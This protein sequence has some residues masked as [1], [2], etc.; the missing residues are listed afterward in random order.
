MKEQINKRDIAIIGLS[1]K[2]SASPDVTTFWQN[3]KEGKELTT[4]YSKEELADL[5][6]SSQLSAHPDFVAVDG[7]MK[8]TDQFD[9]DFFGYS[10]EEAAVMDPQIRLFHQL[11]WSAL[12][13]AAYDPQTFQGKIGLFATAS[14]NLLWRTYTRLMANEN[15]NPFFANLISN[16][17]FISLLPAFK[18]NLRGPS[19]FLDTAC[20]SS[21]VAFHQACR[22]LML[23][24]CHMA[25]AGG[26]R[27]SM[28]KSAGYLYEEGMIFSQDGH[29]RTFDERA[30]GTVEGEGGGVVVLKRLSEAI[31][32]GDHIYAIVKATA[33][34]NDGKHK[35]GFTAPSV[36]GQSSC[37]RLAYRMAGV[38]PATVSYVE[39]HGTGTKLGDP[40][41]IGALNKVFAGSSPKS[42]AIGSVKS[43]MGHLDTAAG[44]TGLI[45]TVLCLHH[46]TLPPS[47]NFTKA[48][49]EIDFEGGPFFVNDQLRE[50]TAEEGVPLRAGVSSFG[51]GGTNAHVVLQEAPSQEQTKDQEASP[52][53][54]VVSAKSKAAL[55]RQLKKLN[56][57]LSDRPNTSL[58]DLAYTMQ[59]G[60]ASFPH[61]SALAFQGYDQLMKAL[62]SVE[63]SV[64]SSLAPLSEPSVVFLFSGAGTQYIDMGQQ[65]YEVYPVFREAMDKGF[66]LLQK[67]TGTDYRAIVYPTSKEDRRINE[68]L[69]TQP[70]IFLF[71]Y[72]IAQ[73]L[74]QYGPK[75]TYMIGHSLGE[76]VAACLSG[77]F[78]FEDALQLVVGRGELMN[79]MPKGAMLSV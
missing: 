76:Y 48:N 25:M 14:D 75:P 1:A 15:V 44:I 39:A 69:Y 31:A 67:L 4:T 6:V 19:F 41:E 61:R 43:N 49:P 58:S 32:D 10:K 34:N 29:C 78:S 45:K 53:T 73:L 40:I 77:V 47:I 65:L 17:N 28:D 70:V 30:T 21:L 37:I 72:A 51:L 36:S 66:E 56:A 11:V 59:T 9:A 55:Q 8:G 33:I 46:K 52:N 71:E 22:S 13:D 18:L 38:D 20:S 24:E 7:R 35:V 12:E 54:L 57:F 42:C 50:W 23:R 63:Q 16:K 68:M 62:S 5:G 64:H 3:L 79:R 60:R 2:F 74:M 26:V 27:V